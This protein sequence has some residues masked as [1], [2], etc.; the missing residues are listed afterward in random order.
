MAEL[1][2]KEEELTTADLAGRGDT[3][4]D[5][6]D[7]PQLVRDQERAQAQNPATP[8]RSQTADPLLSRRETNMNS[9]P[10]DE[11]AVNSEGLSTQ[12][13][14]QNMPAANTDNTPG[15]LFSASEVG[16][17]RSRW[18]NVQAGFVDEP[19]RAVEDAGNL[20]ASLMKK[21]AEG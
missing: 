14:A 8:V 6:S 19:R 5:K 1:K 20:V 12:T 17:Y 9:T 15:A 21:L 13:N 4:R 10:A 2:R 3:V 18:S 7:R 11:S 16:D